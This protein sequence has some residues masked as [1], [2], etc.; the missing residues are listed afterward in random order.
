MGGRI[1]VVCALLVLIF[2]AFAWRLIH[3]QVLKHDYFS[4]IAAEKNDTRK[5]IPARRGRILDRNGEELAVNIPVQMVYADGSHI[6]D[7]AAVAAVAAPFLEVPLQEL[8]EKLTTKSKYVII[9]KGVS[10]EKA[11]DMIRAL[12]KANLHGLYLQEGSV[13]SYPNGEMLC[14]VL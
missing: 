4:A 5:V 7:P 2:T 14:D 6:H 12:D 9:R 11:Q 8:K 1:G 10:E 3:L 13:R